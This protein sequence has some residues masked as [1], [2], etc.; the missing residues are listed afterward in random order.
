MNSVDFQILEAGISHG[1][2]RVNSA[3]RVQYG[4]KEHRKGTVVPQEC[5]LTKAKDKGKVASL[6]VL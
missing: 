1:L 3:E 4:Q 2:Y 6:T 5:S